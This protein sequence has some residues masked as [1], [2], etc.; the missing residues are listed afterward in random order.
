LKEFSREASPCKVLGIVIIAAVNSREVF[1]RLRL[2]SGTTQ[3]S[4]VP[5]GAEGKQAG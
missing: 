3:S 1:E 2:R 4:A 5:S